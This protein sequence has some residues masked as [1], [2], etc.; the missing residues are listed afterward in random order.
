MYTGFTQLHQPISDGI[1]M[2][3]A[4]Q[5]INDRFRD[6]G[7]YCQA[8]KGCA[9]YRETD[10]PN[11]VYIIT[12]SRD[13]TYYH[14]LE[15]AF[16]GTNECTAPMDCSWPDEAR[17]DLLWMDGSKSTATHTC[18]CFRDGN[19]GEIYH[20]LAEQ[21]S[22]YCGTVYYYARKDLGPNERMAVWLSNSI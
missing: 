11:H 22:W 2:A 13:L 15:I 19:T 9:G 14:E 20:L 10:I 4:V 8:G 12:A 3:A 16:W 7:L 6:S 1:A 17:F 21:I 18:F 5:E